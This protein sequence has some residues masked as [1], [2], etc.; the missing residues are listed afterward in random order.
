MVTLLQ[1]WSLIIL[2]NI[3]KLYQADFRALASSYFQLLA[4]FC[5]HAERLVRDALDDFDSETLITPS[6]FF[7]QDYLNSYIQEKSKFL[8]LTTENNL[9]QLLQLVLTTTHANALQTAIQTSTITNVIGTTI[10]YAYT[11]KLPIYGHSS[12]FPKSPI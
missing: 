4:A 9:L 11:V 10:I 6:V 2:S 1:R 3:G 8:K 7:S 12:D 5:L